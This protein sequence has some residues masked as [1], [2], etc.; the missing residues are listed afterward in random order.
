MSEAFFAL[1]VALA[2][3]TLVGHGIWVTLAWLVRVLFRGSRGREDRRRCPFC[4][5]STPRRHNR[6]EWCGRD[7]QSPLAD[8]LADL[9]GLKRQVKRFVEAG[10]LGADEAA[11]LLAKSQEYRRRLLGPASPEPAAPTPAEQ[12]PARAGQPEEPVVAELVDEPGDERPASGSKPPTRPR[13]TQPA[14]PGA[15]AAPK[16][17]TQKPQRPPA[18]KPGPSAPPKPPRKPWADVLTGFLEERN[19]RW[20]EL[21]GVLVGGLLMVGASVALV[22]SLWDTLAD[23][24]VFKFLVF[25][26]YSSAVF[27]AGLFAY[28]RWRLEATGRGLLVIGTLLVP[29]NFLAMASLSQDDWT[30]ANVAWEVVSVGIFV[31]LVALAGSVLVPR[32]RWLQAA[33]VVGNSALV[34]VLARTAGVESDGRVF[35]GAGVLPVAVFA[36]AVGGLLYRLSDRE[37]LDPGRA[38]QLFSL[39]GT[40][41]FALAA[42]LGMLIARGVEADRV[43]LT[44]D[45]FSALLA[46][47][48][49]PV[50]AAGL[51]VVRGMSHDRALGAYRTAGTMIALVGVIA[52]LVALGMA[53][54]QP[55]AVV[56]V[57]GLNAAALA[58][59]AFRY[60]FPV[61]HAGAIASAAVTYLT[62]YHVTFFDLPWVVGDDAGREML[63][64]AT[65]AE[66][67]AALVGLVVLLGMAAE[68]LGRWGYRRHAEQYTGGCVIVALVSLVIVTAHTLV[69]RGADAPLAMGVYGIYGLGS[70]LLNARFRKPLLTYFGLGLLVGATVWGLWWQ[71][72]TL[73][74]AVQPVWATILLLEAF[75]MGLAAVLLHRLS[76]HEPGTAWNALRATSDRNKPVDAYR[77]PLLHVAEVVAPVGL[78][79]G[80]GTALVGLGKVHGS[81]TPVVT[82][83]YG[84]A[85]YLLIAWGYRSVGRTWVGSMVALV[86][87]VHALVANYTGHLEQPW[88][89]AF[90]AH[91]T[92]AVLASVLLDV[93][94]RQREKRDRSNF[95][96]RPEGCFAEIRP[97]PFFFADDVR[98]VFITPLGQTALLSSSLAIP[99]LALVSW[100]ETLSLAACLFW[101][102]GI[103]LVIA[104][105]NRWPAMM[106]G[107]Q[108]VLT[109]AVLVATTAWL[110]NHPWGGLVRVDLLDPRSLQTYGIGLGLLTLA[111]AGARILLRRNAVARRLLDPGWPTV[112]RLV[113]HAVVGIQLLLVVGQLVPGCFQELT[114]VPG[115]PAAIASQ[116]HAFGPTAWL[117]VGVLAAALLVGLWH[118]WRED[119]LAAGLLLAATVP[120]LVAGPFAAQQATASA[121]R[122]GLAVGL[123]IG[124]T[125]V[126]QRKGVLGGCR[127]VGGVVE[128]GAT[129]PGIGRAVVLATTAGPVLFLTVAAALLQLAGVAPAGPT[130]GSFFSTLG[131]EVSYLVP[132]VVVMACLVG[133]ALREASAAYAFS[134]GLVAKMTVVLAFLLSL[135]TAGKAIQ[136][137]DVVTVLELVAVT[138]AVWAIAWMI[139]RR[140]A[141]VWGDG[142]VPG[143]A[144]TLMSVQLGI[145]TTAFGLVWLPAVLALALYPVSWH[146]WTI[147]AGSWLGWLALVLVVGA[148]VYRGRQT[149]RSVQPAMAGLVGMATVGLLACSVRG[150][151]LLLT[152]VPQLTPEWGYRTLMLGWGMYALFVVLATWWVATVRTL[153][154]AQ[155]PPQ[156]LI[157]AAAVW[158][159]AAGVLAVLLGIKA[160]VLH[161][162][163]E[164][165]LWAAA[166]IGLA[167]AAGAAMSV[168]RCREG[169]AF[170]AAPGVNLAASLVVW[171]YQRE[172]AFDAWWL[173]LVEANVIASAAVALVWL[174]ARKRLYELRE[175]TIG[176]SPL[177]AAQTALGVAGTAFLLVLPVVRLALVP[178]HLPGWATQLS[179]PAGWIALVL[180]AMAAAWY[181]RQVAPQHLLHVVGGLGLGIGVLV[182]CS[183]ANLTQG[184]SAF[185]WLE[186]HLLTTCWAAAGLVIL[187][188]GMLGRNLRLAGQVEPE[189]P[190][191]GASGRTPPAGQL[192][193][194]GRLVGDWVTVVG[195]ASVALALG[196]CLQDPGRPWWSVRAILAAGLA[197]GLVAM[198]LRLPGYVYVSGLLVNVAGTVTWMAWESPWTVAGSVHTNVLCLGVASC[199]WSLVRL[200]R[201]DGAPALQLGDR[202][203]PFADLAAQ[204]APALLAV[205]VVVSV[206]HNSLGIANVPAAWQWGGDLLGWLA[207]VAVGVAAVVSFWNRTARFGWPVLYGA[208]LIAVGMALDARGLLPRV[209]LWTAGHE[210]AGFVLVA[211]AVGWLVPKMAPVWRAL[212]TAGSQAREP[213]TWLAD[214][215]AVVAGL[216][217]VLGVWI[218]IDFGFDG[219]TRPGMDWLSG[220]MAGPLATAALMAAAILMAS[221][222]RG[223][224]RIGWQ[225]ATFALA[226]LGL[227]ELSWAWLD[228]AWLEREGASAWLHRNVILMTAAVVMALVTQ[229][230][231]SRVLRAGSDWI[232][233]GRRMV[234]VLAGLALVFLV[235]VLAQEALLF[236]S[237]DGTPMAILA[238]AVVA[239]AVAALAAAGLALALLP[240]VDPL[241]LSDRRRTAYVYAA[242]VLVGL[243]G[244]HL[245]LT[246]PWLFRLGFMENY[247]MLLVIVGAFAGASLSELFH[248]RGMPVLSEPLER[249]AVLLPLAP[250]I[251]FWLPMTPPASGFAGA[252][253]AFWMLGTLFYGFLA[254]SKRSPLFSVIALATA[255]VGLCVLWHQHG[256]LGFFDH[257]QLWLIPIGLSALL[258]EHLNYDRLTK[259]QSALLRYVALSLIYVSSSTEFLSHLGESLWL[260]LVLILLSVLGV[261][262]GIVL[263]MRSFVVLGITFLTLVIVTMIC[264]AALVDNQMW[265]FWVF[266]ICVAFAIIALSAVLSKR[267]D[268]ILAALMRFRQWQRRRISLRS[269]G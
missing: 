12:E 94:T 92:L 166:A 259:T 86:G 212:R 198:W 14:A 256:G 253:P 240:H 263:R 188:G 91:A 73:E 180:A 157:R 258:A 37:H 149:G 160:A 142:P 225:Y 181:L 112:D 18:P 134:A 1:L 172:L 63:Q 143:S 170:A 77:V 184:T 30:L 23:V 127:R 43:H 242:E 107:C 224:W 31:G 110:E 98:R 131:P 197:A 81:P 153:P 262:A 155:G 11:E 201:P 236:E 254:I 46:L 154:G 19:I 156:A 257:P 136:T 117:L 34:L 250:A 190:A 99:V 140:W 8:E 122:W 207:L 176:T 168:W 106:A 105:T 80:V 61:A 135:V 252:S 6:C 213:A 175:L 47:A 109:L 67:G 119:E 202:R 113:G 208:G 20:A 174:A 114:S 39:V 32:G 124:S 121:L 53:W 266:C 211:A 118:R 204:A 74:P 246:M 249:T 215:Q 26:T 21:V 230:G 251:V 72:R 218:S 17:A 237:P 45:C 89:A 269:E 264:H 178:S 195:T 141:N 54:P 4:L 222:A 129:G 27:G 216:A 5:R 185:D 192:V 49:I 13:Q 145:G 187:G 7:L 151:P 229:F 58:L 163:P 232:T 64:R 79:V 52:M 248:R 108:A 238:I 24:P 241:G 165:L 35:L 59:V 137:A 148:L 210:L 10:V 234:P 57:G 115:R 191:P 244:A 42:A 152:N 48:A 150:L 29:L 243:V 146:G 138:A 171:Y 128:V 147:A 82:A 235:I 261:L 268:D 87:L 239:C 100:Q 186:Y 209:F 223:R 62:L 25:V 159:S 55:L 217:V 219:I 66:S 50:L 102:G 70:L 193:F 78:L 183:G 9:E 189:P 133:F 84:A 265:I 2:I 173:L 60:R 162:Q 116:L 16:P 104:W 33:G 227:A 95:L 161:R 260:P 205:F 220:R 228:P 36:A 68:L 28:W 15:S 44:L 123:I 196:Y 22:I 214:V 179:E 88:L 40:T 41:A 130:G 90:L 139:G 120:C 76:D 144:R 126:W 93:W 206:V 65:S 96:E 167:S 221:Q 103:W 199:I 3:I 71:T 245:W 111:W 194:P 132:L 56:A 233:S 231:L 83:V 226:A 203:L 75:V 85:F 158:V 177:L 182:A 267:H 69:G 97:V 169:W 51:A 200:T 164:D 101:L 247:W 255:N 125:A 38:G